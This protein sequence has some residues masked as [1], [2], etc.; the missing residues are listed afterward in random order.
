MAKE[1]QDLPKSQ[2]NIYEINAYQALDNFE[3]FL[4]GSP[5]DILMVISS[6]SLNNPSRQAIEASARKLGFGEGRISWVS[7]LGKTPDEENGSITPENMRLLVESLDPAAILISDIGAMSVFS[8]AYET[9]LEADAANRVACR[10]CAAFNNFESM[11]TSEEGKQ[12]AWHV[13]KQLSLEL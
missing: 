1:M 10:T 7:I 6:A 9:G 2:A 12:R 11:L 8:E 4:E 3:H 5:N 13:L